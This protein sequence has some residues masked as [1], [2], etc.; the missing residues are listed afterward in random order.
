MTSLVTQRVNK[1]Y[2]RLSHTWGLCLAIN[3]TTAVCIRRT[4]AN[5]RGKNNYLQQCNATI[6]IDIVAVGYLLRILLIII[7]TIHNPIIQKIGIRKPGKTLRCKIPQP[8]V[9]IERKEW[10]GIVVGDQL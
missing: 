10:I 4:D 6:N 8:R 3:V 5:R 9:A 2:K 7:L 1:L